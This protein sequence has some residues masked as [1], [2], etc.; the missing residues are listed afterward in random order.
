MTHDLQEEEAK[1]LAKS[2]MSKK[3]ARLYQRMQHG[4]KSK[5][6]EVAALE[7]KAAAAEKREGRAGKVDKVPRDKDRGAEGKRRK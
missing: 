4:I 5:S 6:D 3:T 2:M 1:E 7:L